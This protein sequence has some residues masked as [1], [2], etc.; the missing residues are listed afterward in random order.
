MNQK[1]LRIVDHWNFAFSKASGEWQIL[2]C[3]DDALMFNTLGKLNKII[4][5]YG[6]EILFGTKAFTK[7]IDDNSF[8]IQKE[9][10]THQDNRI[11]KNSD[12]LHKQAALNE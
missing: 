2:L 10:V 3:D 1:Y 6:Y 11:T 5:N 7:V 9:K 12:L 8:H 4:E